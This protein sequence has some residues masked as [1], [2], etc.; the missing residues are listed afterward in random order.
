MPDKMFWDLS[1]SLYPI[2]STSPKPERYECFVKQKRLRVF[3]PRLPSFE[4]AISVWTVHCGAKEVSNNL[5]LLYQAW[6]DFG[7]DFRLGLD[8]IELG[9]DHLDTVRQK[10]WKFIQQSPFNDLHRILMNPQSGLGLSHRIIHTFPS[11]DSAHAVLESAICSNTISRM[12]VSVHATQPLQRRQELFRMFEWTMGASLGWLFEAMALDKLI[13]SESLTLLPFSQDPVLTIPFGLHSITVFSNKDDVNTT[14]VLATLYVPSQSNNPAWDAF[15]VWQSDGEVFGAGFQMTV[16]RQHHVNAD[17]LLALEKR[18]DACKV[19][20]RNRFFIFV[21][22]KNAE[23]RLPPN[24]SAAKQQIWQF[25]HLR[26]DVASAGILDGATSGSLDE[27]RTVNDI[28]AG[29]PQDVV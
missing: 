14:R 12:I 29:V 8:I 16:G 1:V 4:E 11:T 26:L 18:L 9:A 20:P 15:A 2:L 10:T 28:V 13:H 25:Y 5:D 3:Y 27:I 24:I 19:D 17:G 23:Y 7:V 21:T 6:E 22:P